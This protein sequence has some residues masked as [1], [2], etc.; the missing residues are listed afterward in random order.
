[1]TMLGNVSG[2][3]IVFRPP[4]NVPEE[5]KSEENVIVGNDVE[6]DDTLNTINLKNDISENIK[7][8]P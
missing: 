5:F 1:M 4:K 3:K 8:K 6:D 2:V 7:S